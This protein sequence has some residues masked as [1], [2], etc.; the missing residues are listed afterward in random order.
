[1][2]FA[3]VD[4]SRNDNFPTLS[5]VGLH[6]FRN[7]MGSCHLAVGLTI[8]ADP[9]FLCIGDTKIDTNKGSLVAPSELS[10]PLVRDEEISNDG[11]GEYSTRSVVE[12]FTKPPY[13]ISMD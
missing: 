5:I 12:G 9:N 13:P 4:R 10:A 3:R 8:V 11:D 7:G 2:N 1:M 6:E